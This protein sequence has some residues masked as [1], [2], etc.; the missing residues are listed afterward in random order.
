MLRHSEDAYNLLLIFLL[1]SLIGQYSFIKQFLSLL[2]LDS[3]EQFLLRPDKFSIS[4]SSIL[5]VL[6]LQ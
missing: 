1:S 3:W 6:S 5:P 2:K 4:D